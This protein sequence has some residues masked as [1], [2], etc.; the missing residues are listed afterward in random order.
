MATNTHISI[1]RAYR[2]FSK[3]YPCMGCHTVKRGKRTLGGTSGTSPTNA[4]GMLNPDWVYARIE[5]SHKKRELLTLIIVSM[6]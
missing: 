6:R 3:Q 4:G 2:M 5:L 1:P